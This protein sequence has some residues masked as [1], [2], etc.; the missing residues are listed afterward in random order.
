[1]QLTELEARA[2]AQRVVNAAKATAHVDTGALKRSISFTY[3]RGVIIF[4]QLYYGVYYENSRLEDYAE[5]YIP[6]GQP[7][8]LVLTKFGGETV[9]I[10]KT[11]GGRALRKVIKEYVGKT[12]TSKIKDLIR[13]KK[14]R[15]A[16]K[17]GEAEN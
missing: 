15:D 12:T 6:Y 10:G 13:A 8:K 14:L 4:R 16:L 17:N 3:V 5:Q 2:I 9:E 7:W 11:A 1:M